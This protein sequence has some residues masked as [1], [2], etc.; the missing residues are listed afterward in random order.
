MLNENEKKISGNMKEEMKRAARVLS[1][2]VWPI[3]DKLD[4]AL[5]ILQEI[6]EKYF[7]KYEPGNEDN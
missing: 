2:E 4:K 7:Q 1:D 3:R 6:N 5:I